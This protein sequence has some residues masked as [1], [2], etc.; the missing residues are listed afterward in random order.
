MIFSSP[1]FLSMFLPVLLGVYFCAFSSIRK[2]ILLIAS[3]F[4]YSW[5]EPK[6]VIAMLFVI[7][8]SYYI[9]LGISNVQTG[10]ATKKKK[11]LLA[12]GITL[13]LSVLVFYKYLSFMVN[14]L[15]SILL[16]LQI[17]VIEDP[18]ID[19]PI[20]VSFYIFQIISYLIDVYRGIIKSQKHF[21]SFAMYVSLF[22]QLL[23]GPIVRY[24]T[25]SKD[26]DNR[27]FNANNVFIGLQRFVQG[28]AKK[29]LI[30]DNIA[31]IANTVFDSPASQI[32][33]GF[34]WLG[35]IAYTLQIY[36]DFS[37]YSDMAIGLARIFNFKY[38]ENFKLPYSATSIQDFWRR[39]HISLS[40]WFRDYLYI[41]LGGNRVSQ[42]RTFINLFIVFVLCGLWHG[43]AW[44]FVFWGFFHGIGLIWER[45]GLIKYINRLPR[46]IANLYVM[47]F[48]VI[49]WVFFRASNLREAMHYLKIMFLGNNEYPLYTY[50]Q[51]LDFISYSN[52]G[53]LLLAIVLSYPF[54]P[55]FFEKIQYKNL[56]ILYTFAVF[57][58]AFVW[59]MTSNVSPFIYF[60][61]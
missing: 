60:R 33:C 23:S 34:A 58:I 6:A 2:Y 61:F 49:G 44:N 20:G 5:G 59:A 10:E 29:V 43:A 55:G 21:P 31:L 48:V 54:L 28:L 19:L 18:N 51:A 3:I 1:L 8:C 22:P 32:P 24:K 46:L 35:A 11:V 37:G 56:G 52:V 50:S 15:N 27:D 14:I 36:Y 17:N 12:L 13:N 38:P 45:V 41:P 53:F 9:A 47:L 26:I 4:F 57:C 25:L 39:W 16:A 42:K 30:A 7:I 40:S